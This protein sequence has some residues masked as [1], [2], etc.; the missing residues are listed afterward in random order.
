MKDVTRVR[1]PGPRKLKPV[2]TGALLG[3]QQFNFDK[4]YREGVKACRKAIRKA[5]Q[6]MCENC[7]DYDLYL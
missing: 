7:D 6:V 5:V 2:G 4:G 3:E 1:V